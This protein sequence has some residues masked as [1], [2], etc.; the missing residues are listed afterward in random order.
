MG[1]RADFYVGKGVNA[2]W[3]GSIAWDG[4]PS[5]R[6]LAKIISRTTEAEYR[7]AVESLLQKREDATLPKDGWPWPWENSQTTDF[8]YTF[9]NGHCWASPFGHGW[10]NDP[11]EAESG[12][13][14]END[15]KVEFP[16]MTSRKQVAEVGSKKSGIMV[17]SIPKQGER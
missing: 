3:L 16:D 13:K 5:D 9:E 11:I 10:Y 4:Y 14:F 7:A 1:T 2:E 12:E 6:D 17:F 8:S 15:P